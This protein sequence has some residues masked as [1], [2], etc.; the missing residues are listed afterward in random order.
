MRTLTILAKPALI[1]LGLALSS[2]AH[3][4]TDVVKG[5]QDKLTAGI[6]KLEAACGDDVQKYCTTVT[7]GEGRILHCLQAHED[8]VAPNCTL[9]LDQTLVD[10]QTTLDRLNAAMT[11]CR[12]D[13]DKLCATVLP[14][15]GRIAAC[16]AEKHAEVTARCQAAIQSLRE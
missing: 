7:P 16:L 12:G 15:E 13:I 10:V 4:Q 6:A 1:V 8:K 5:L 14:G 2:F 9:V 11:S 3:G